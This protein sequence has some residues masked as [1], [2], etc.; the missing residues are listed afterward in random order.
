VKTL[1]AK[2]GD[3]RNAVQYAGNVPLRTK[4][5][6]MLVSALNMGFFHLAL[7]RTRGAID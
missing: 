5:R 4:M 6:L 3:P 1:H 7:R 2:I